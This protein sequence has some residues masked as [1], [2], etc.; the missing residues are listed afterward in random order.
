LNNY[1]NTVKEFF[2]KN[3]LIKK[4]ILFSLVLIA[5]D[6]ITK[7]A[8]QSLLEGAPDIII[9]PNLLSLHFLR[10]TIQHFHQYLTY[11][12]L[13]LVLFPLIIIQTIKAG[14]SRVLLWGMF[15]LWSAVFSNNI[16][17]AFLH[18]YIRDFI[19][20]EG[21]AVGNVA[22]QYRTLGFL[23]IIVGLMIKD[24]KKITKA[25]MLKIAGIIIAALILTALFWRYLA[26]MLAI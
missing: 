13:I 5:F 1:F 9:I 6:Q 10:N 11:F 12:L 24:E 4:L 25:L 20:L 3:P 23:L 17:D 22:D 15:I 7:I 14:S 8:A 26:G 19:N 18:G 2:A 16:I 21:I